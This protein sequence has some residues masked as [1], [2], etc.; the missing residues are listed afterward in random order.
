MQATLVAVCCL[1]VILNLATSSSNKVTPVV[2]ETT[3]KSQ[4][5]QQIDSFENDP[6]LMNTLKI[7]QQQL[8]PPG[9]N[10][11]FLSCTDTLRCNS[12][13]SSGYYPIRAANG[14]A[15]QVYCDMEGTNCGG[16]GGWMRVAYFNM[17]DPSSQCPAGFRIETANNKRFC[18][19]DTSSAG[20]GS[21]LFES[22]ELPYSQVCGYVRGYP[23][24]TPDG[25]ANPDGVVRNVPLNGNYV[26]GVSIT[27][28]TPPT[29]LWT[30]VAGARSESY[31]VH[32][33]PCNTP[34]SIQAPSFISSD[35]YCEAGSSQSG[36]HTSDPLWDGMQCGS[37]EVP[38]CN[39]TGLPWFHKNTLT[40]TIAL[41]NVRVCLDE[42]TDN[43]NI[44]IE[45][46]ELYVK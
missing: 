15:V 12:S 43:E 23:M 10:K 6:R 34:P 8:P 31:G 19:R 29:H 21:M 2:Y 3:S 24:I 36:W 20:C 1:I 41:I 11:L 13:A 30:Y 42:D 46:L 17:T 33:C 40:L 25:F 45:R 28:G 39:H 38:C 32:N 22:F 26:D 44:G 7:V 35:F 4:C 16:E 14:S 37:Q 5:D 27:Y 9:C 18:I